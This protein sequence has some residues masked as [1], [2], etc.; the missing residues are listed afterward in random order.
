MRTH[1]MCGSGRNLLCCKRAEQP[2]AGRAS[3]LSNF[4]FWIRAK[5]VNIC[6][7]SNIW[8]SWIDC[9][10]VFAACSYRWYFMSICI[11]PV[12]SAKCKLAY[13]S[14]C[15]N[16]VINWCIFIRIALIERCLD[17]SEFRVNDAKHDH[18]YGERILRLRIDLTYTDSRPVS[19]LLSIVPT[20]SI[21]ILLMKWKNRFHGNES[22]FVW[23][24][25]AM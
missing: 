6:C 5:K 9:V 10:T 13:T 19:I 16:P 18:Q 4:T 14:S 12:R 25:Y 24:F 11:T 1:R 17:A 15:M 21:P 2:F 20:D 3:L 22:F 8:T 7:F 23:V